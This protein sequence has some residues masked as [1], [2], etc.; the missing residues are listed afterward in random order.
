MG[1][2]GDEHPGPAPVHPAQDQLG[3]PVR[4]MGEQPGE[5]VLALPVLGLADPAAGAGQDSGA[6]GEAVG[7]GPV[8]AGG[9]GQPGHGAPRVGR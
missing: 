5:G 9:P 2:P 1:G 6:A 8:R 3:G 4:G 7:G